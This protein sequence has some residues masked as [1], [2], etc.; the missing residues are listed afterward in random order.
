MSFDGIVESQ[1]VLRKSNCT[2]LL[3]G[4]ASNFQQILERL[5]LWGDC[6]IAQA[7]D[8]NTLPLKFSPWGLSDSAHPPLNDKTWRIVVL[9]K[10]CEDIN[11]EINEIILSLWDMGISLTKVT[12]CF[13]L[14]YRMCYG[15]CSV[16]TSNLFLLLSNLCKKWGNLLK[17]IWRW[18]ALFQF[19]QEASKCVM[20]YEI[21]RNF[22]TSEFLYELW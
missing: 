18:A 14:K 12:L 21:K 3:R 9:K 2:P 13:Q 16:I 6:L 17:K 10:K 1:T 20:K 22:K 19:C 8:S 4:I 7:S 5:K 15:T 11:L